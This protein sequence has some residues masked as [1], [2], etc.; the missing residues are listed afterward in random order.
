MAGHYTRNLT[1]RLAHPEYFKQALFHFAVYCPYVTT[2]SCPS[3]REL[4]WTT[5]TENS[6]FEKLAE[7]PGPKGESDM[8]KFNACAWRY[9]DQLEKQYALAYR[10]FDP[11]IN[12]EIERLKKFPSMRQLVIHERFQITLLCL[13]KIV[14]AFPQITSLGHAIIDFYEDVHE[15]APSFNK[16][17]HKPH[18]NIVTLDASFPFN[19]LLFDYLAHK[20]PNLTMGEIRIKDVV[21]LRNNEH[22]RYNCSNLGKLLEFTSKNHLTIH[23]SISLGRLKNELKSTCMKKLELDFF[24]ICRSKSRTLIEL[25]FSREGV[26]MNYPLEVCNGISGKVT[27]DIFKGIWCSVSANTTYLRIK[28]QWPL[29]EYVAFDIFMDIFKYGVS[30]TDLVYEAK[31]RLCIPQYFDENNQCNSLKSLSLVVYDIDEDIYPVFSKCCP[32]LTRLRIHL[33]SLGKQSIYRI[34]M[35]GLHFKLFKLSMSCRKEKYQKVLLKTQ[36][37]SE[38]KTY[39][40]TEAKGLQQAELYQN[41]LEFNG[42]TI[43]LKCASLDIFLVHIVFV[44]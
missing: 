27:S 29:N 3:N 37:H 32:Q 43:E 14:D 44:R 11:R 15:P 10:P 1:L 24:S 25:M 35:P 13:D 41:A 38:E 23:I 42:L 5:L 4:A 2:I 30:L 34:T 18:E 8:E 16:E 22:D 33:G 7:I 19:P 6:I 36:M 31:T 17:L 21:G 40:Y 20:F 28:N 39:I 9:R 12:L 26:K